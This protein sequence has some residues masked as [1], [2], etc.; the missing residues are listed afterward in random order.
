MRT[1]DLF[2]GISSN[3]RP[4]SS[5]SV[6]L[7]LHFYLPLFHIF[8]NSAFF[9]FSVIKT[10]TVTVTS[11][12]CLLKTLSVHLFV[13]LCPSSPLLPSS[14]QPLSETIQLLFSFPPLLFLSSYLLIFFSSFALVQS[15]NSSRGERATEL[16]DHQVG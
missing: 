2:S 12:A 3:C 13:H 6:P 10:V 1:L 15:R 16:S 9:Y 11:N 7:H 4:P 5:L 14:L 8:F